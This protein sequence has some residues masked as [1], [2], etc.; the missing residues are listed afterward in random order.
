M[1][2]V[3]R[4]STSVQKAFRDLRRSIRGLRTSRESKK[5]QDRCAK[6]GVAILVKL[7]KLRIDRVLA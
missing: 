7:H 6:T 1:G 5:A 4:E 2:A 3:R